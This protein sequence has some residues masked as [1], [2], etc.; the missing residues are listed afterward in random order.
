MS[1]VSFG[2]VSMFNATFFPLLNPILFLCNLVK[3]NEFQL[4]QFSAAE[5]W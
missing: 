5:K 3:E 1:L 2:E 4:A